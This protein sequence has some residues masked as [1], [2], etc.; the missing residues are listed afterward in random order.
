MSRDIKVL[1]VDDMPSM[2]R[3][4]GSLLQS[5]GFTNIAEAENG[6]QALHRL[7]KDEEFKCVV[8]D[9]NMPVMTGIELLQNI[10]ADEQ[11]RHLPVLLVTAEASRQNVLAAA[12]AGA[13]GYIVKPFNSATLKTKMD[14]ILRLKKDP[15]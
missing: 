11:L 9:W 8:T 10:R 4:V 13:S 6:D 1:I 5:I 12:K 7:R 2:R 3:L 14:N 15:A